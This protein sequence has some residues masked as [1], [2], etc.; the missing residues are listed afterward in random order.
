MMGQFAL[1]ADLAEPEL[2]A[3]LRPDEDEDQDE[4][5]YLDEDDDP[6]N[7]LTVAQQ[8]AAR[9]EMELRASWSAF[10]LDNRIQDELLP[11]VALALTPGEDD[12]Y[13]DV[14]GAL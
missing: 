11:C 3:D 4:L 6:P 10:G 1:F 12:R 7:E 9:I 2:P 8:T 13:Y 14:W 5:E